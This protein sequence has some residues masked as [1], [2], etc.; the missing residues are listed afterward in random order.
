MA[1]LTGCRD[2]QGVEL[3]RVD[4]VLNSI[5]AVTGMHC[6]MLYRNPDYVSFKTIAMFFER[7]NRTAKTMNR[8]R[9]P[10]HKVMKQ[11]DY[12]ISCLL[13]EGLTGLDR[14]VLAEMRQQEVKNMENFNSLLQHNILSGKPLL[15]CVLADEQDDTIAFHLRIIHGFCKDSGG[16]LWSDSLADAVDVQ[17]TAAAEAWN[18]TAFLAV[19]EPASFSGTPLA[20]DRNAF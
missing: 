11:D 10:L 16:I 3:G 19:L 20:D 2:E 15:W 17:N 6:N 14:R 5:T 18:I 13:T 4:D 12:T 8:N 7:Y 1:A 9:F